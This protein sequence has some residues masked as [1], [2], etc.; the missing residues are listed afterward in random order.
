MFY[1]GMLESLFGCP[2]LVNSSKLCV[3]VV[4]EFI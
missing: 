1:E 2:V 3:V 4:I